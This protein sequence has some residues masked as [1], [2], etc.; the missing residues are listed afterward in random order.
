MSW[1]DDDD[2]YECKKCKVDASYQ[3]VS[4]NPVI[5][6][7]VP[8]LT[9]MAS[10]T[11]AASLW[12]HVNVPEAVHGV[13]QRCT[14]NSKEWG[15]LCEQVNKL[16][17]GLP[18]PNPIAEQI[19]NY[20][21][22]L[23]NAITVWVS[24]HYRTVFLKNGL[25][26]FLY[27]HVYHIAWN[28]N[29]TIDCVKTAKNMKTSL[30]LSEVE[31]LR[32]LS[33]YCLKEEMDEM[34]PSLYLSHVLDHVSCNENPLIYYW[35]RYFQNELDK[36]FSPATIG[37]NP[38]I[39]VDVYML[40]NRKVDNWSAKQYFFDR[41]S[42]EEQVQQAIWLIDK[43]G[44][45]YQKA[46][47]LKLDETQRLHVYMKRAVRIIINY[48][49]FRGNTSFI[50]LTWSE[51]RHLLSPD[52]FSTLFRD[53]LQ[54][55]INDTVLT[56]IWISATDDLK[57]HAVSF[58]D[59]E[60]VR[61]VLFRK[62]C[63]RS[64]FIFVLLQNSSAAVRKAIMTK[65]FFNIYLGELLMN[66]R[67]HRFDRLLEF[68][69]PYTEELA[70]FRINFLNNSQRVRGICLKF[71]STGDSNGL[72]DFLK[73][74]V[75]PCPD[76]IVEYKKNLLTSAHG[77]NQCIRVM[78][79]E[80]DVLNTIFEASLPDA[81][82][83]AEFKRTVI[84]TP[85]VIAKLK[86]SIIKK[87]LNVV[88]RCIDRFL[89]SD[90]D[91]NTLKKQLIGD[92]MELKFMQTILQVNDASYLQAVTIWYFGNENTLLEFKQ[93]LSL[94]SIFIG[95]LKNCVF[96]H[97]HRSWSRC[98]FK[99]CNVNDFDV[100]ERFLT[101]YFESS[102]EVKKY[103]IKMINSYDRI[104][105]FS[106]ILKGNRGESQLKTILQWVFQNDADEIAKFKMR[107]GKIAGL[108]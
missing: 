49:R 35:C 90:E 6:T 58:N 82:S 87:R 33:V 34:S 2:F 84:F 39:S 37:E 59:H 54:A 100:I 104:D 83:I 41:L 22:K 94:D 5:L 29:G 44:A 23:A 92:T 93:S 3:F 75:A 63:K 71:Y 60:I 45:V 67:F 101:W 97:Y 102:V 13:D 1:S 81:S 107:G 28:Q 62:K 68:C 85:T 47:M 61:S 105:M 73:Q 98:N 9:D 12:N 50:L 55:E 78:D 40:R 89:T 95:M 32:F 48:A 88:Q 66:S 11:V 57:Q 8:K 76:I 43:H 27:S 99:Y 38:N 17:E 77:V 24:Y 96:Y 80:V 20:V 15:A 16:I 56:E 65:T 19:E 18:V 26:K 46:V 106:T 70:R 10:V 25:D 69:L 53:L 36:I 72:N 21:R 79:K 91:K 86:Y 74:L 52:Q 14:K 108:L 103:K 4:I 42:P 31:K 30:R 64:E 51:A 7:N